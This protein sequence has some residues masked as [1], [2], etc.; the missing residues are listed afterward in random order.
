MIMKAF[1][2]PQTADRKVFAIMENDP[3]PA[4]QAEADT[5]LNTGVHGE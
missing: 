1:Q 4:R 3:Q 2:S 5:T